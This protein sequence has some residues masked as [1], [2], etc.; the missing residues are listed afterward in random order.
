M[1]SPA[2]V[3]V[4]HAALRFRPKRG[5]I[6]HHHFAYQASGKCEFSLETVAHLLAKDI[7][8][9][10]K[11]LTVPPVYWKPE[12]G[13]A[14]YPYR[15]VRFTEA[16]VEHR[17]DNMVPDVVL[18]NTQGR[19]LLVEIVVTHRASQN[20]IHTLVSNGISAVEVH[21]PK[22]DVLNF[23]IV[24]QALQTTAG[25]KLWL[26]SS[27]AWDFRRKVF[28]IEDHRTQRI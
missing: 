20:K 12:T 15:D 3:S 13:C 21:V 8:A 28:G 2:A 24:Q 25:Q 5:A 19:E 6:R 1:D 9:N 11:L 26:C 22:C 23:E 10:T 14:L 27:K 7:L 16:K 18:H 4:Q 17:L